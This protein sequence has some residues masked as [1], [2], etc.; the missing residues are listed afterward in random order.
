MK[1][2][3][4]FGVTGQDGF[5]LS[6]LL[7]EKGYRVIGV[8]RRSSVDNTTRLHS[9]L[10]NYK[11][12]EVV[13]G[14]ITDFTSVFNL[15]TS[16]HPF[17]IYNLAAQSHVHTSFQQ[18]S[19]TF[20]VNTTGVLNILEAIRKFTPFSTFYQACHDIETSV[21]T[22][23]GIKKYYE[24][25]KDDKVY[26]INE[27][28]KQ[29]EIKPISNIHIF[30]YKGKMIKL[31]SRRINQMVTPNHRVLLEKDN[32]EIVSDVAINIHKYFKYDRTSLY[33]MPKG[34]VKDIESFS[35]P[36]E[37]PKDNNYRNLIDKIDS[38]LYAIILGLYLGDGHIKTSTSN[39][40]K[41]SRR[42]RQC[43]RNHKGQFMT[44]GVVIKQ[45]IKSYTSRVEFAIPKNDKARKLIEETLSKAN[46]VYGKN[47]NI[48]WFSCYGLAKKLRDDAGC[49]FDKKRIPESS[50]AYGRAFLLNLFKGMLF[51]DGDAKKTYASS[52]ENLIGDFIRLTFSLGYYPSL[53]I[54][55]NINKKT[56][57]KKE[58]RFI[59][60]RKPSYV[61][62]IGYK[63]KNKLYKNQISSVDY[64]NKVWCLE[65]KDNHNFL[66][67]RDGKLAFSGNSTSE[68]FGDNY[69]A[70][71]ENK[72]QNEQTAF[73]PMS[74][75]AAAK[76]AAH[77]L[78]GNYRK[79]YGLHGSCGI[80]FNHDSPMRGDEFVTQK[81][82]KYVGRLNKDKTINKL[83]LGNLDAKRDFGHAEEYVRAMWLMLQQKEPD[84][85]V[86]ATGET[87]TV[88]EF[89][90]LAFA[91]IGCNY[92]N[93][94]DID[95]SL[96]RPSEVEYLLGKADKAYKKLGWL[97]LIKFE[98]LV[99]EM[100]D[101]QL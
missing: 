3:L 21:V 65:V 64:D 34:F 29:I 50:F 20:Q 10:S 23:D 85:Y 101:A 70:V 77:Y 96:F 39:K 76:V 56:Y 98:Q 89:C 1:T 97:P 32:G 71:G 13:E 43:Y 2:A 7:L 35:I 4:V 69:S 95:K 24:I 73:R 15:L 22:V 57:L 78:V 62:T 12:F 55:N 41:L 80:L 53:K 16:Y 46:I 36:L 58:N 47:D 93:Y 88:R 86:V 44:T 92:N 75:Y 9:L 90:E 79:A 19:Y 91:R 49:Y 59:I 51:S 99:E 25:T 61:V 38:N 84:D 5:Y 33:S 52:N 30:D 11:T 100:V 14:D 18:P 74:P 66:V 82:C 42:D 67:I 87:H 68:M 94:V 6:K 26:S 48:V 27:N 28:T 31:N 37:K 81:I 83:K 45:K 54:D 63:K 72:F 40:S 8:K 60:K 17:E